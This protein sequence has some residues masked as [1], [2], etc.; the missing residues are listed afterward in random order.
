MTRKDQQLPAIAHQNSHM[1]AGLQSQARHHM[2][3]LVGT[4]V[5]LAKS[6]ALATFTHLKGDFLRV[7]GER[8]N[9]E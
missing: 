1:V 2:G 7:C 5:E 3:H 6:D 9:G 8:L 4:G